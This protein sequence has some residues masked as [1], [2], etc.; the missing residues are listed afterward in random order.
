MMYD[1]YGMQRIVDLLRRLY[2]YSS[3]YFQGII[4]GRYQAQASASITSA[5]TDALFGNSLLLF[6][7]PLLALYFLYVWIG[8]KQIVNSWH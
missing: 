8:P 6:H 4:S 1:M 3:R 5:K 7:L 2:R